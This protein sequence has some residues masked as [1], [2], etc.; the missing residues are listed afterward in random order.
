MVTD[1]TDSSMDMGMDTT[2]DM[3]GSTMD[4]SDMT[5]SEAVVDH[6][7]HGGNSFCISHS[8]HNV[9]VGQGDGMIMYM[10]GKYWCYATL[11]LNG[12]RS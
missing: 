12:C 11:L 4:H 2:M 5:G 10:D 3:A 6:T 8:G 7:M 9:G 1:V